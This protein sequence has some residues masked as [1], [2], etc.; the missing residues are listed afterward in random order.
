MCVC[1]KFFSEEREREREREIHNKLPYSDFQVKLPR[2]ISFCHCVS[3]DCLQ[4]YGA[5]IP[6]FHSA[7]G[8][9]AW[10]ARLLVWTVKHNQ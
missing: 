4:L 8:S 9:L 6:S 7:V 10:M 1:V 2:N 5:P 3:Y